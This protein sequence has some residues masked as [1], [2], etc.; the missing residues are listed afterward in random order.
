MRPRQC[1]ATAVLLFMLALPAASA[2]AA[3]TFGIRVIRGEDPAFLIFHSATCHIDKR[4]G[5]QAVA[6][7]QGWRLL[8]RVSPFSGFHRRYELVRGQSTGTFIDLAHFSSHV[9]YASDFVPPYPV[10][11]GGLIN[12]SGNGSMMGAGFLLM[13]SE[14]GSHAVDV[15]GGLRCHYP[16][17]THRR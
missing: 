13:F 11:G 2:N 17:H 6:Y 10:A 15:A 1:L 3:D 12:F 16:H 8:V 9:H 7:Q 5:F 14:D 4:N